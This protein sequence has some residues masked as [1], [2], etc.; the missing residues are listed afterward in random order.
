MKVTEVNV[1]LLRVSRQY[2]NN[3]VGVTV[4]LDPGDDPKAAIAHASELCTNA[5]M[6]GQ[7]SELKSKFDAMMKDEVGREA[8][9]RFFTKSGR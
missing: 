2:E 6:E 3:R 8:L 4:A 5:L 1:T 9:Y 7:S